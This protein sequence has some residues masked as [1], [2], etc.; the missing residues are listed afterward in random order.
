MKKNSILGESMLLLSA[1]IWGL[2]FVAQ[3]VGGSMIGSFTFNAVRMLIGGITLLPFIFFFRSKN[4]QGVAKRSKSDWVKHNKTLLIGGTLCGTVLFVASNLQ[5]IGI[6]YSTV[7]K[8]GFI[9]ALYIIIVP[10]IGIF[11]KKR[12]NFSLWISIFI[13]LCGM[14]FLCITDGFTIDSGDILLILSAFTFSIHILV[15]DHYSPLVE[16]VK[17]SCIQFF[18]C[19][20]L[21]LIAMIFFEEPEL[22]SILQAWL[23]ILYTG[24]LSCGIAYTF[25]IL[26]QKRVNHIIASLIMSLESVFS[27]LGG[28]ILLGESL[29]V[30]E[31]AGC[32]LLF[33][34]II[35]A[36]LPIDNMKLLFKKS[37]NLKS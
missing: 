28:W 2:A 7:S 14:Y 1:I 29:T 13:A 6:N 8:A 18:V 3:R 19:G 32:I 20:S 36:Q 15:I 22:S 24:I 12:P 34:A 5:Q 11:Y 10:V 25:Q 37:K 21:S 17:L 23:P 35:L 16:G 9:T 27:A 30:R 31:S 26:G 33:S 4:V